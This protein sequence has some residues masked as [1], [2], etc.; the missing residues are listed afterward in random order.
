MKKL[1]LY[2]IVILNVN[3]SLVFMERSQFF[4]K[5]NY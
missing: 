2:V 3:F 5:Y 4:E 1:I